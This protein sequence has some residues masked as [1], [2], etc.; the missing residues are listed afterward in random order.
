MKI[1]IVEDDRYER[2]ILKAELSEQGFECLAAGDGREALRILSDGAVELILSD[3]QMPG[4]GG[5]DLLRK[6]RGGDVNTPFI[7]LTG[8]G[9]VESAVES[10]KHG[11]VDYI[12]KPYTIEKLASVIRRAIN[13]YR[14]CEEN[15]ELKDFISG[16]QGFDNIIAVSERMKEA[17]RMG[18]KAASTPNTTVA[19]F[20]ESGTGKEVLARAIHAEG[21]SV[22]HRFMAINCAGVPSSLMESELFGHV[23]GAFTGA[24]KDRAGKLDLAEGG[25]LLLDEIGDMPVELQPKLLRVLEER[26]YCRLGSN[27]PVEANLRIIVATHR[28]LEERV[29]EGLF[30]EDLFHRINVFPITLP[31]LRER[32]EDIP[33]LAGHFLDHFRRELGKS[34]PGISRQAMDSLLKYPWPGNVRE[35]INCL[36]RAAILVDKELIQPEHLK[37][38]AIH[39]D[40]SRNRAESRRQGASKAK[41]LIDFAFRLPEKEASLENITNKV[42]EIVLEYC[43]QNKTKAAKI[44]KRDRNTFYRRK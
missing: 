16:Q 27:S 43:D 14:V 12:Q 38:G 1:L 3:L 9:T 44:L 8:A 15:R 33:L 37:I 7:M 19:I 42:K 10:L 34:L 28:N 22:K 35:L 13:Y 32:K 5:L 29:K 4:M 11:A 36:E 30:R 24:D 18:R 21:L 31:P 17:L 6:V 2:S 20:G 40:P 23:K 25:T 26:R 41:G 39:A